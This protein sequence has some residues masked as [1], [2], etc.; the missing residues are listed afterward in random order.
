MNLDGLIT[1][2]TL[3]FQS[4]LSSDEGIINGHEGRGA[5]L[6][7]V[8]YILDIIHDMAVTRL[9]RYDLDVAED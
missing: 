5:G 9:I 3:S 7:R 6:N 2:M 1:R 8:A 4:S